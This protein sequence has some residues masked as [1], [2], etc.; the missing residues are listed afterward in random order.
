MSLAGLQQLSPVK[1]SERGNFNVVA[2]FEEIMSAELWADNPAKV[3]EWIKA[4]PLRRPPP[5]R[6]TQ[7]DPFVCVR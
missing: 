5:P 3:D 7:H 1:R 4:H 6:P 2:L